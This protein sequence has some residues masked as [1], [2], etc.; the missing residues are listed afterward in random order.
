[1]AKLSYRYIGKCAAANPHVELS[2]LVNG[3]ERTRVTFRLSE[4]FDNMSD[5]DIQEAAMGHLRRWV[6]GYRVAH[7][8]CTLPELKT[9]LEA[10]EWDV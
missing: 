1:M 7:P 5:A 4:L 8:A 9:A 2:V 6:R 10:S 3:A